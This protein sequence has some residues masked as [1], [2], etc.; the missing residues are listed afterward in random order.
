MARLACVALILISLPAAAWS[1][2]PD[3]AENRPRD[4]HMPRPSADHDYQPHQNIGRAQIAPNT[5]FGF[6][7]FG[8]SKEKS[9]LK[10]VT[11]RELDVPKQRRASV[12][13]LLKF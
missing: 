11:G 4:Y 13:F 7:M 9:H 1:D 12:G 2:P 3:G 6:G 5:Q 8:L 10:P